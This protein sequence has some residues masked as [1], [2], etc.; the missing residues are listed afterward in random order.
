MQIWGIR[1]FFILASAA[2]GYLPNNSI[3]TGFLGFAI[4]CI[5]VAS[6][7]SLQVAQARRIVASIVGL[8]LGVIVSL[9]V[10]QL[11]QPSGPFFN[12]REELWTGVLKFILTLGIGYIGMI[13]GYYISESTPVVRLLNSYRYTQT[14]TP[15]ATNDT[16]GFKIL[17]TSVI[18]DGR[19]LE[20]CE[21]QFIDGTLLIPRFV[22]NELQHIAD[23]ADILRKNKGRRGFDI[24]RSLQNSPYI[25]VE[26][27]EEDVPHLTEVDAKLVHFAQ[28]HF[29]K[30]I[31]N[32]LNLNKV[33]ELQ[34]VKVLNINELANA[35]RPIVVAGEII[36]VNLQKIGK[37]PNQGVGYLD[38]GTMVIVED[39]KDNIGQTLDVVVT[40]MLRTST[41]QMI[42]ARNAD[43]IDLEDHIG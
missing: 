36:Q 34:G 10:F 18:I 2:V 14:G 28:K 37:E 32:D 4:A 13:C 22:L 20:I 35:I 8:A 15:F 3:A 43:S 16:N 23:S 27:I 19:I 33:A 6:E 12:P 24:L 41:G 9:A 39:G 11:L 31:T 5:L 26:I 17:D 7:I 1:L 42:F 38:D 29:A 30:I 40:Q 25:A 21:T